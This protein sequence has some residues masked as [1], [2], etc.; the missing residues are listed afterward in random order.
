MNAKNLLLLYVWLSRNAAVRAVFPVS[1]PLFSSQSCEQLFRDI[2]T[3]YAAWFCF[4]GLPLLTDQSRRHGNNAAGIGM[5]A[6]M[7]RI[8]S[9][10]SFAQLVARNSLSGRLVF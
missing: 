6:L 1:L 2:R 5:A 10:S 7:Q 4:I 9:V 8:N 3:Q